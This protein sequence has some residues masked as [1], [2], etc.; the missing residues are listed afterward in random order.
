MN[1]MFKT[2]MDEWMKTDNTAYPAF[3]WGMV[4]CTFSADRDFLKQN[5]PLLIYKYALDHPVATIDTTLVGA[6]LKV[7]SSVY[8]S[9][10]F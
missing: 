3:S 9:E 8:S 1:T 10:E 7:Q 4:K 5:R 2:K 6:Y